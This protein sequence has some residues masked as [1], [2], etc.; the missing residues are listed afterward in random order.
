LDGN[1]VRDRIRTA[2]QD[3]SSF[4][5]LAA[6]LQLAQDV[7]GGS[8]VDTVALGPA[9]RATSGSTRVAADV[10][11]DNVVAAMYAITC[12]DAAW[13]RNV[14]IYVHDVAIARRAWPL[15]AGM[16]SNVTPC[17]FWPT[18]PIEPPVAVSGRGP[19]N[20][21][22]L[23]NTRDPATPWL[24][25]FGLRKAL[26]RRVAMITVNEGGHGV[27]G[28]GSCADEAT[29]FYLATGVLPTRDRLCPAP[30]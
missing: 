22:I 1:D 7:V 25:G 4:P 16:P 30:R 24:S 8:P 3:D 29:N 26:G 17:T 2:L 13:P 10:P 20:V 18:R 11:A 21:L 28:H 15:T 9:L 23:Q 27:Y 6:F 5:P 19:R 14:D 12:D